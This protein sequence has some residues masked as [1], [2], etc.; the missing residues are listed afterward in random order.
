MTLCYSLFII[1]YLSA[2]P[3]PT[4]G[5]STDVDRVPPAL[6][7]RLVFPDNLLLDP[8]L[9]SGEVTALLAGGVTLSHIHTFLKIFSVDIF[10]CLSWS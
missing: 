10:G 5:R 6:S 9:Q 1:T 2:L 7:E 4:A 3:H 8:A